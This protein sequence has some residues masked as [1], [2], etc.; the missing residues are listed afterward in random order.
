MVNKLHLDGREA[1]RVK[2][3]WQQ[4]GLGYRLFRFCWRSQVCKA[5][6]QEVSF[7][8]SGLGFSSDFTSFQRSWTISLSFQ[9]KLIASLIQVQSPSTN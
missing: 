4:L 2:T 3:R 8:R 6:S 9:P 7:I 5:P 1:C